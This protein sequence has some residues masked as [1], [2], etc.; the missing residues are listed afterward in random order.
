MISKM[1]TPYEGTGW[2]ARRSFGDRMGFY[3]P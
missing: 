1:T 3:S 2:M